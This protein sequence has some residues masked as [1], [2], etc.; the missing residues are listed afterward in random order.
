MNRLEVLAD[1][2][3]V[4][5]LTL[6]VLAGAASLFWYTPESQAIA[7]PMPKTV[8]VHLVAPAPPK[9]E[10]HIPLPENPPLPAP[11]PEPPPKPIPKRIVAPQ[12]KPKR[13]PM[14][15]PQAPAINAPRD[16]PVVR[17]PLPL[18]VTEAP[19]AKPSVAASSPAL[20]EKLLAALLHAVEQEKF[21]PRTAR[22]AGIS[23]VITV[24]FSFNAAGT[25]TAHA[26][27]DSSAH[28]SLVKA[29]LECAKQVATRHQFQS[30]A[31][32]SA[33][34]IEVPILYQ[35]E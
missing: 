10:P 14:P 2:C 11:L 26:L 8:A 25:I 17:E 22:R 29:A 21:Y 12:E 7:L 3:T 33:I 23:G 9:V 4:G 28:R 5:L 1:Q 34:T 35:L 31:T 6:G 15:L 18:P 27:S 19:P 13:E 32:G 30:L 20:Q 24:Q 16:E